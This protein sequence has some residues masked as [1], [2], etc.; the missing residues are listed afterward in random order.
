MSELTRCAAWRALADHARLMAETPMRRLFDEDQ[1]RAGRFAAA[2]GGLFLDY[3]KNR[4]TEE[5]VSLLE[6]LARDRD[7]E[8]WRD[9]MFA[10]ERINGTEDRAVLHVALRNRGNRSTMIDGADVMEDVNA[11]R[12]QMRR[13]VETVHAG[14]WRGGTG[15]PI[16]HVVNIGIGGSHLGP[17]AVVEALE[18]YRRPEI[19]T[20]FVANVDGNDIE[21]VLEHIDP[22]T[23]LFIIA[24]K[25]FTTQETMTNARSARDWLTGRL[26]ESGDVASHFVA[27]STNAAGVREFGIDP[28]NMF[29]FWDWV[30]GRYSL[31]SAIGLPIALALGWYNFGRL[32]DGAHGMDTHF[33]EAPLRANLPVL[34]G[35]LGVWNTNFLGAETHAVLPYDQRLDRFVDHLQ[36]LDMES[37]G[38]QVDRQGRPVDYVTGPV[39]WGRP[40]TNGQHAFYQLI[41]QGTRLVPA[42]FIA[43]AEPAHDLEGH[44][45]ILLSNVVAQTEALMAGKSEAAVRAEL[46]DAGTPEGEAA[47]LAPY[48]SFPGNVP[49][50][51]LI[52][53]RLDPFAVGQLAALYEHKVFVQGVIWNINSFDQWGVELGKTLAKSVLADLRSEAPVT[54]HDTSTTALIER[55]RA[56]PAPVP[57]DPSQTGAV[58]FDMDGV[59]TDTAR[60]HAAAW[61][62]LFDAYLAHR[63]AARG[64]PL[65][66]FT[67]A[68]Y[69]RYVDGKPRLE[70]LRDFL[71]ARE[72][73]L[74][75]GREEDGPEAETLRGLG[76]AKTE[77]FRAALEAEGVAAFADVRP[78]LGRLAKA[79]IRTAAISASRHAEIVLEAAGLREAFDTILEGER[80]AELGL[81]GK[82]EP[83]IFLAAARALG[84]P[85]ERAVVVEDSVAGVAASRAGGFALVLGMARTGGKKALTRAGAD[86]AIADLDALAAAAA[87]GSRDG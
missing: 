13:F 79:G 53:D 67:M 58:I 46:I 44:H 31:W 54:G 21:S 59:I 7:L 34:L 69:R 32:L 4:I 55:L 14:E 72:I 81:A 43:V 74:P 11:V 18:A 9:R 38:K 87:A 71:A 62:Q 76:N 33:I 60:L 24:S 64:E 30:G 37:N 39:I 40:G 23:S 52:L 80:A 35:L 15:K 2:S 6:A 12:E 36:Q 29:R 51:T 10:G 27:V 8:R 61:K 26:G 65:A 42:D 73:T 63:A 49:T 85:P 50:N 17:Q 47:A 66:P 3:S 78:C 48:R 70:G 16:R 22:E 83:D 84:V 77:Y 45:A 28:A 19:E 1:A 25:T 68:D 56:G 82:P 86:R 20:H 75:E 5:T 41:H 57:L